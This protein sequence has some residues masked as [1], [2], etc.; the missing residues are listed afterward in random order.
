MTPMI[1][2]KKPNSERWSDDPFS[3][4]LTTAKPH[5]DDDI[6]FLT[7]IERE[8]EDNGGEETEEETREEC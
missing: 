5:T 6:A 1:E 7:Q 8:E 3:D 4:A 2:P